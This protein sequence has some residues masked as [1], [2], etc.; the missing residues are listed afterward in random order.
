MEY[1]CKR[2][3]TYAVDVHESLLPGGCSTE[4]THDWNL[5]STDVARR[6]GELR[7]GIGWKRPVH[8]VV[9]HHGL[10]AELL[11]IVFHG[12][13]WQCILGRVWYLAHLLLR[14]CTH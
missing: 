4:D 5:T 6:D 2:V 10:H 14:V 11:D 8:V 7:D 12:K 9:R 1:G 3:K 13:V